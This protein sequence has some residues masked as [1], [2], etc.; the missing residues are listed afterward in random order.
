ML[1]GLKAKELYTEPKSVYDPKAR[2][3]DREE[4]AETLSPREDGSI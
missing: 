4:V 1:K 3:T 2:S